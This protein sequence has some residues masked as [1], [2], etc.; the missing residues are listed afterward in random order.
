VTVLP[1][2]AALT[3]LRSAA[4]VVASNLARLQAGQPP[5]HLVER[6]RGY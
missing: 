5:L 6:V 2:V 4:E 1:H 3:D